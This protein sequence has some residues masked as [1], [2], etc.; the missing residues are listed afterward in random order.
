MQTF[1]IAV[2][3]GDGIGPEVMAEARRVL[4]AVEARF[5]LR[6]HLTEA[7]VGGIAI[8][9]D[10]EALPAETLRICGEAD[11]ILFGSAGSPSAPP[12]C[13]CA[14]I[15]ASSPTSAPP[16]ATPPSHTPRR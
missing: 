12:C 6:F 11:A 14:S 7:R 4:A 15:S 2:L 3:P 5:S 9:V 16:S 1:Q 10:G 8:D 13:P